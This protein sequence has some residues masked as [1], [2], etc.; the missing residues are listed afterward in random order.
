MFD[1]KV[2][3]TIIQ[4]RSL[5]S[6]AKLSIT[7]GRS[8][9]CTGEYVE[10]RS[11]PLQS[12][13][14]KI[15][16]D[17]S[18]RRECQNES[19]MSVNGVAVLDDP[20]M[21][22]YKEKKFDSGYITEWFE[23]THTD[24]SGWYKVKKMKPVFY[25]LPKSWAS[26]M[27]RGDWFWS[28]AVFCGLGAGS[29]F[30]VSAA[31]A[32][33]DNQQRGG[34]LLAAQP[35]RLTPPMR[36]DQ[37]DDIRDVGR[38]IYAWYGYRLQFDEQSFRPKKGASGYVATKYCQ[39]RWDP[40]YQIVRFISPWPGRDNFQ[41]S[42]DA[43]RWPKI[44][45]KGKVPKVLRYGKTLNDAFGKDPKWGIGEKGICHLFMEYEPVTVKAW[46][47]R[48]ARQAANRERKNERK[49]RDN[50]RARIA[51][52]RTARDYFQMIIIVLVG[53]LGTNWAIDVFAPAYR[54]QHI[55]KWLA[56]ILILMGVVYV[57]T[58]VLRP[59]SF[60]GMKKSTLKKRAK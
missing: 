36:E 9:G 26:P 10:D 7:E 15:K 2:T 55:L 43:T 50:K 39:S 34:T 40:V 31:F 58:D 19:T 47:S 27:S 52:P 8:K 33:K 5:Y 46:D 60:D 23:Q 53:L 38:I 20:R 32:D 42:E 51:Q 45:G 14:V 57:W 59:N 1:I 28:I 17:N 29:F 41:F 12:Q 21:L 24:D 35:K 56:S 6:G 3:P 11:V 37:V 44:E 18:Q 25:L 49:T 13:K 4:Y 30:V 22:R 16:F 54:E 48:A